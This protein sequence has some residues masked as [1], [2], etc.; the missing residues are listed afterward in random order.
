[1]DADFDLDKAMKDLM[2]DLRPKNEAGDR[3]AAWFCGLAL[4]VAGIYFG[5][6]LDGYL[7]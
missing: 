7:K 2:T 5:F 4:L 6:W 3:I 1:M